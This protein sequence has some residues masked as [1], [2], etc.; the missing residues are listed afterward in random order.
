[1]APSY[2]VTVV[3]FLND[4]VSDAAAIASVHNANDQLH[5]EDPLMKL[6][7]RMSLTHI[8]AF[9]RREFRKVAALEEIHEGVTGKFF[10]KHTPLAS[11]S[12]IE[13]GEAFPVEISSD[14]YVVDGNT[15]DIYPSVLTSVADVEPPPY[16]VKV[17]Y[18]GG[19]LDADES[20]ALYAA[21]IAQTVTLYN[22]RD[23]LGFSSVSGE[24]GGVSKTPTDKGGLIATVKEMLAPLTYHG[25]GYAP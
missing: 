10:V 13:L 6:C 17:T 12:K 24:R 7:A 16:Y 15:I 1:M 5:E 2:S 23:M 11:V 3:D 14:S 25:T 21:L 18:T 4:V 20:E 19:Y 8:E 22:R 9:C